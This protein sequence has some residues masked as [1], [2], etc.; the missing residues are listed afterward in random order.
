MIVSMAAIGTVSGATQESVVSVN[1]P[2]IWDSSMGLGTQFSIDL[3]VDYIRKPWA[4]QLTLSFDPDVLQ[5]VS[6][7]NGDFMGSMGG[8]VIVVPGSG[9]DN[10]AGTLGLFGAYLDQFKR[11]PTGGG[12][13]VTVTFEVAGYG[14][15]VIELGIETGL[16][17]PMGNWIVHKEDDACQFYD[18]YFDNVNP[19]PE[20][21]IEGPHGTVGGGAYPEW[22]V[23]L[24]GEEQILYSKVANGEYG[25]AMAKVKFVVTWIEGMTTEEYWSNEA[26]IPGVYIDPDTGKKVFPLVTVQ[27]D[28]FEPGPEGKYTVTASLYFKAGGMTE[29]APYELVE[30]SFGGDGTARDPATKFKVAEQM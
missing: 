15:T 8:N 2:V 23:N 3:D 12:T 30:S 22:H 20:L 21:W 14:S 25:A 16:A 19:A 29:Y 13:L 6:V 18:G 17:D 5:G 24:A 28:P 9:F 27:T 1:P 26:E 11:L 4:Y 7:E 10:E